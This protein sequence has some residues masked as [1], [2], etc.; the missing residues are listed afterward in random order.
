ME[1]LDQLWPA[2]LCGKILPIFKVRIA[3]AK[4]HYKSSTMFYDIILQ[5]QNLPLQSSES[6]LSLGLDT[7][8]T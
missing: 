2:I 6:S 8:K 7:D 3:S 5:V 4:E 1:D